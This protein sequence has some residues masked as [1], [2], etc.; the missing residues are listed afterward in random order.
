MDM[1]KL[2]SKTFHI[3]FILVLSLHFLLPYGSIDQVNAQSNMFSII[4]PYYGV[5]GIR[6]YFDHSLPNYANNNYFVRYDGQHWTGNVGIANCQ[7]FTNCYDGHNGLDIDMDYEH[8]LASAS[9]VVW[10]A[11]YAVPNCHNG[12]NCSYGLQVK[13][14][15]IVNGQVYST[16]Y[17][18][19]TTI[20]VET[21]QYIASGQIIGT[22]GSTGASTGPHLHFD[23]SICIN[24]SCV[25]DSDFR[26]ID[27]FGWKPNPGSPVQADPWNLAQ[28]PNGANSWCMWSDGEF[29]THCN[30]ER[31]SHPIPEPY[32][33][34]EWI[35]DDTTNNSMGFSKGYNGGGNNTCVGIDPSCR[36][37]WEVSANGLGW[38]NHLYKTITNGLAGN[39][40]SK[41]NWAR[42]KPQQIIPGV[43]EVFVYV[44]DN[45][46]VSN[47][48]LTWQAHFSVV[49]SRGVQANKLVDEYIG[50]G[51]VGYNPRNKWLSLGIHSLGENSSV[52][53]FDDG[54]TSD[55]HCPNGPL[56]NG[57]H[58]CVVAADAVK[59]VQIRH[60]VDIPFIINPADILVN[61]SFETGDTSGW[62]A[63]R[64][65]NLGPIVIDYGGSFGARLGRYDN[66]RDVL[67]QTLTI[68]GNFHHV[69]WSYWVYVYS[70]ETATTQVFD[71]LEARFRDVSGNSVL[72]TDTYSNLSKKNE[73]ILVTHHMTGLAGKTIQ[74]YYTM[75][76]NGSRRTD[77]W[78]E[79]V[80]VI[81]H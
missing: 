55:I 17:A 80:N 40:N 9:G 3:I 71:Q 33:G 15:H 42:W 6:S 14:K 35:V 46:L 70:E 59:F 45:L 58:W 73:W 36:E 39:H 62:I 19:L 29:V 81:I 76:T 8:V 56:A 74:I 22:S 21:G 43:Y 67:F 5:K 7:N 10:W 50:E 28:N 69:Q 49:D 78:I 79:N 44:P 23:V 26:A 4:T 27:P 66:N 54:E 31:A 51:Q 1:T 16:R 48:T 20:A 13:I 11:N 68:P 32:Y 37:W 2:R 30:P 47:N 57:H 38:G 60:I 41:D 25:I 77:I 24:S 63:T 12:S 52:Y 18:H 53:V 75:N 61:G 64:S 72:V 34:T 65:N